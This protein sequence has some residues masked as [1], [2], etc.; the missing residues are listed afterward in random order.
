MKHVLTG[1]LVSLTATVLGVCG[2]QAASFRGP[3]GLQLYSLRAQFAKDLPGTLKQVQAWG[4]RYVEL[5]GTY[6]LKPEEF[7]KLLDAHNIQSIAGHF[8]YE[9]WRDD[10]EGATREAKALGLRYAGCAWIPH[11][12]AF[13]EQACRQAIAVF[14]KAGAVLASH[15]LKF[16]YHQHGYEFRP[17]GSGTLMDLMMQETD[18]KRVAFEMDIFWVRY[19][20]QDP[21][22]WLQK[23]S[24]RWE[25]I[26]LKDM[27]KGV[28]TGD[29]SGHADVAYDVAL[30]TGQLDMPAILRAARKAGVKWYFI[31]DESPTVLE[32]IPVSLKYLREVRF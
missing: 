11:Q 29:Q 8:P 20:G 13:D 1:L 23:Y 15:G 4:F 19:P 7:K 3:L 22:Q 5:A 16:F 26:H 32:Q 25:L 18:P 6:N 24:K 27:K 9:R 12:G 2:A 31:E 21:V 17:W 10:P 28:Q 14:N 30:G